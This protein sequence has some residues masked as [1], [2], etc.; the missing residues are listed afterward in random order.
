MQRLLPGSNVPVNAVDQGSIQVEAKAD[1]AITHGALQEK[2]ATYV[3]NA[4]SR[5]RTRTQ[6]WSDR[7]WDAAV[8]ALDGRRVIYKVTSALR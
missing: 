1:A 7:P 4:V 5:A 6:R 8:G 2:R 3:A